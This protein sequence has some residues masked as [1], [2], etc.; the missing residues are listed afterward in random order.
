MKIYANKNANTRP[1]VHSSHCA[2]RLHFDH[3]SM[4]L[5]TL[6]QENNLDGR[7]E[8]HVA[9][10]NAFAYVARAVIAD[11][12]APTPRRVLVALIIIVTAGAQHPQGY[13]ATLSQ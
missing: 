2:S 11:G 12:T 1:I 13:I 6:I 7:S 3:A 10:V 5:I 4:R 8:R 9:H